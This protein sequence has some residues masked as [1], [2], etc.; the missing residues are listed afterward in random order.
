VVPGTPT[1]LKLARDAEEAKEG[2]EKENTLPATTQDDKRREGADIEQ[3]TAIYQKKG[4]VRMPLA[5]K[6]GDSAAPAPKETKEKKKAMPHEKQITKHSQPAHPEKEIGRSAPTEEPEKEVHEKQKGTRNRKS[7]PAPAGSKLSAK[8]EQK[9][10]S[11]PEEVPAQRG[12]AEASLDKHPEGKPEKKAKPFS[13]QDAV[14]K[15]AEVQAQPARSNESWKTSSGEAKAVKSGESAHSQREAKRRKLPA[16]KPEAEEPSVAA[17]EKSKNPPKRLAGPSQPPAAPKAAKKISAKDI[18]DRETA[19]A[20]DSFR[21]LQ[22][23]S[24]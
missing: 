18:A 6:E 15:A 24:S 21:Q 20:N 16:S 22:A 5:R 9:R 7:A 4:K 14:Q 12:G 13:P 8:Q 2:T 17:A 1:W 11:A 23:R 3:S 19:P 10:K